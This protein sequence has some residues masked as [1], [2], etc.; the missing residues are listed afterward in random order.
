[1]D[2]TIT[3]KK[4][5]VRALVDIPLTFATF[6][7]LAKIASIEGLTAP[8][9]KGVNAATVCTIKAGKTSGTLKVMKAG[10]D[11]EITATVWAGSASWVLPNVIELVLLTLPGAGGS[12]PGVPGTDALFT[13]TLPVDATASAGIYDAAGKVLLRTLSS[14]ER[15]KKG[16]HLVL[17]N[18]RDDAGNLVPNP[19]TC[20][21]KVK[22]NNVAY[23]YQGPI[24]NTSTAL[25]GPKVYTQAQNNTGIAWPNMYG[26]LYS[27]YAESEER[28]YNKIHQDNPNERIIIGP[29]RQ[30]SPTHGA[31]DGVR[32]Y[33]GGPHTGLNLA[34][35]ITALDVTNNDQMVQF[36]NGSALDKDGVTY[37]G[38]DIEGFVG[39]PD[40]IKGMAV[41]RTGNLL[42]VAHQDEVRV[43]NK[44]TGEQLATWSIP[45][46]RHLALRDDSTLWL[47]H[48]TNTI[49]KYTISGLTATATGVVAAGPVDPVYLAVRPTDGVL[50]A[51]DGSRSNDWTTTARHQA[52][53]FNGTTGAFLG[54][55]GRTGGYSTDPTVYNDKFFFI[56]CKAFQND[57]PGQ[58]K[59]Y[60]SFQTNGFRWIGDI[61]NVRN[62][63]FDLS[64]QYVDQFGWIGYHYSCALDPNNPRRGFV[65]YREFEL[66]YPDLGWRLKR[67]WSAGYNVDFDNA[68]SRMSCVT[69][70]PS[71]R[72]YALAFTSHYT[73]P[74]TAQ[75]LVELA[76][77]G[78]VFTGFF[79]ESPRVKLNRDGSLTSMSEGQLGQ[80]LTIDRQPLTSDPTTAGQ[81][82]TW[83]EKVRL[84]TSTPI[85]LTDPVSA[86]GY[87]GPNQIT[88]SGI[89]VTNSRDTA[90]TVTDRGIGNHV[91]G[92]Q[93]LPGVLTPT[94]YV[95]LG[96][97]SVALNYK[98]TFPTDGSWENGGP[99]G[100]KA[101]YGGKFMQAIDNN[102][103]WQYNGEKRI[104]KQTNK[105]QHLA[106]DGLMIGQFGVENRADSPQGLATRGLASNA[107]SA[108]LAR[109]GNDIFLMHNDEGEWAAAHRWRISGLDTIKELTGPLVLG[110]APLPL[111]KSLLAGLPKAGA[112]TSGMGGWVLNPPQ[113]VAGG[114]EYGQWEVYTG[115]YETS[116][117]DISFSFHPF[118]DN[119][120]RDASA[121][122][123][124]DTPAS[125]GPWALV[126]DAGRFLFGSQDQ[127]GD[128]GAI[129]IRETANKRLLNVS[130][131][132]AGDNLD[133][134]INGQVAGTRS[135]KAWVQLMNASPSLVL[136]F[137][138]QARLFVDFAD[139]P[140]FYPAAVA[141]TGADATKPA[142]V[143]VVFH[144]TSY[145]EYGVDFAEPQFVTG[146]NV[147][148]PPVITLPSAT[149]VYTDPF[150]AA[151]WAE[152]TQNYSTASRT[153]T[154]PTAW[155]GKTYY[156]NGNKV[157]DAN[158]VFRI[159][160]RA[161]KATGEDG[162][163]IIDVNSPVVIENNDFS[164]APYQGYLI[165][166]APEITVRN[167]RC[168]GQPV[169]S[170]SDYSPGVFLDC[171]N[172]NSAVTKLLVEHNYIT[173][174]AGVRLQN[175]SQNAN[176]FLVRYNDILNVNTVKGTGYR[177]FKSAVQLLNCP[178]IWI[179]ITRNQVRNKQ[180]LGNGEDQ[181]NL[182]SCVGTADKPIRVFDNLIDG[183]FSNDLS[184][185]NNNFTG[186]GTTTD[187]AGGGKLVPCF[188][189]IYD[190]QY[191]RTANAAVNIAG[192][193]DVFVYHNRMVTYGR[194]EDGA[195]I[196]Q[197]SAATAIFDYYQ[198]G[199]A[200]F[201]NNHAQNNLIGYYTWYGERRDGSANALASDGKLLASDNLHL[202]DP[203]TLATENYE[204]QVWEQKKAGWLAADATAI[205]G[206]LTLLAS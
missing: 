11:Y 124:L 132:Y 185:G 30:H 180:G 54:K 42:L 201:Y 105:W 174:C 79:T 86:D 100:N 5:K 47:I 196:G 48:G 135:G 172:G 60:V 151:L 195:P 82:P 12:I 123:L 170:G 181:I 116:K 155:E 53:D 203:I 158:G 167:N 31:T 19:E 27:A 162:C 61:G 39:E 150:P 184:S 197:Q 25:S 55:L 34:S 192:G 50:C 70:L 6:P 18:G 148:A 179:D 122:H 17:W 58:S 119:P 76:P 49:E 144:T 133:L 187:L 92:F 40:F 35:V 142:S 41:Q 20:K 72:T 51:L 149:R 140:R 153:Y 164:G 129:Q 112:I 109:V 84:V 191:I 157:L 3:K 163:L 88:T 63:R 111:G 68:Y 118:G 83:G 189:Y 77:Q 24:G 114:S 16:Q 146:A 80:P 2:T 95:W 67:N 113:N 139:F 37:Y 169:A 137:D 4:T 10:E 26:Y 32:V 186:T 14:N 106:D 78:L 15:Q 9:S 75:Q 85:K 127:D 104:G 120:L 182:Y 126:L 165:I 131:R 94:P 56:N 98:G 156:H 101:E 160:N 96:A 22:F 71:G 173:G 166:R 176:K 154:Q 52:W 159:S 194:F 152:P 7:E 193:H 141:E 1:M 66:D 128:F 91:G 62:L 59:P 168:F 110:T 87:P 69:T 8:N 171:D 175:M 81:Y 177:D 29:Y 21:F 178:A 200:N 198:T 202:A 64:N 108:G 206:N 33:L 117:R 145:R 121:Y 205:M 74:G 130:R 102:I 23:E 44:L 107:T 103:F 143:W 134:I 90:K 99:D 188:V 43:F 73:T 28:S 45:D 161:F 115:R 65:D 147:P 93:S 46:V 57:N 13:Y 138:A 89:V 38:L 190:N 136:G 36:A 97:P 183:A 204:R 199:S 125:A